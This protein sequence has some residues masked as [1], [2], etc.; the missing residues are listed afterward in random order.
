MEKNSSSKAPKMTM[1]KKKTKKK[2]K[3]PIRDVSSFEKE[4]N[5]VKEE[6]KFDA[7]NRDGYA[8]TTEDEEQKQNDDDSYY[9]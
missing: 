3:K 2:K 6:Q 5:Y 7:Y 8:Y 1:N 4:E 9:N